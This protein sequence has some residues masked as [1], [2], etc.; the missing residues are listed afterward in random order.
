MIAKAALLLLLSNA[1]P[2]AWAQ[3][4]P[5]VTG[6]MK[7]PFEIMRASANIDNA[8]EMYM[9]GQDAQPACADYAYNYIQVM[10]I[11]DNVDDTQILAHPFV[12][13]G[14]TF[15]Q[16]SS[17]DYGSGIDVYS[18]YL[19]AV[20]ECDG[21]GKTSMASYDWSVDDTPYEAIALAKKFVGPDGKM[22]VVTSGPLNTPIEGDE[23]IEPDMIDTYALMK[24]AEDV[25]TA[26]ANL[27]SGQPTCG[28]P[29][30][31]YVFCITAPTSS[32]A[33]DGVTFLEHPVAPKGLTLGDLAGTSD[34]DLALGFVQGVLASLQSDGCDATGKYGLASYPWL[35]SDTFTTPVTVTSLVKDFTTTDGRNM[36]C[37]SSPLQETV[38]DME[39]D[40]D[41]P[42]AAT[43]PST[44]SQVPDIPP[45][46]T[47]PPVPDTSSLNIPFAIMRAYKNLDSATASFAPGVN[48]QPACPDNVNNYVQVYD[49]PPDVDDT[50]FLAHPYVPVGMTIGD[51]KGSLDYVPGTNMYASFVNATDDCD[52]EGKISMATFGVQDG[53]TM[54]TAAALVKKFIG[55]AGN[56]LIAASG[57][58]ND[59]NVDFSTVD[60]ATVFA[61]MKAADDVDNAVARIGDGQ[62]ACGDPTSD[63]IFCIYAPP[64]DIDSV[65]IIEHPVAPP[66]LVI[67][68][69]KGTIDYDLAVGFAQGVIDAVSDCPD[70]G[71]YALATYP[72]MDSDTFATPVTVTSLVK[73]FTSTD[74]RRMIC[75]S[76]PLQEMSLIA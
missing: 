1:V 13:S 45:P 72:W 26:I 32:D 7:I 22:L 42:V 12:P 75:G 51:T 35:D 39:D 38:I 33:L 23:T 37:G 57:P 25:E 46:D 47:S 34:Y 49:M 65:T 66:G 56:S 48:V 2:S 28:D 62:P 18:T 67:G 17:E 36:I 44:V 63:Y 8:I 52:G 69:L 58:L 73:D 64:D 70:T 53:Q 11:P 61:L 3:G 59:P 68:T 54:F 19:S 4:Q 6:P 29:L 31:D 76:S 14:M 40:D 24:A 43:D 74:G 10:D 30:D 27:G 41:A 16:L 71:K 60:M 9:K 50:S 55:P 15:G 20:G 5:R 21:V